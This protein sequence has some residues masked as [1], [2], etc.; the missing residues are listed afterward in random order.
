[1]R[2]ARVSEKRQT[3]RLIALCLLFAGTHALAADPT[4]WEQAEAILH[5]IQAP[6]FP[7]RDFDVRAYG[8]VADART[9]S[10]EA[11][12]KAIDDASR[13]GGGRVV[14]PPGAFTTGAIHLKSNV[15]LHVSAGATIRFSQDPAAYLPVVLTRFE[16]V[17][18]W[19]YSPLIYAYDQQNI[20]VTGGGVLEGGADANHWW[21]WKGSASGGPNQKPDRDALF[22]AADRGVPV[23]QRTFGAGHYLRPAFIETYRC[24]NVLIEGVTLKDAPMW[25][26]HPVLS[27]NVTIRGVKTIA[28]GPNT[29]GC[30]PESCRD[31]LI[32]DCY[33][34]NGDD[35]IALKSGRN[36][37]G[38]RV[39][40]PIENVVIRRCQMKNGHGGI[41]IGSEISGGARNIFAEDCTMSSPELERGLRIKTNSVRGGVIENLFFRNINVGEVGEA[42]IRIDMFYEEGDT[43]RYQPIVRNIDV[44]NMRSAKSR[45]ALYLTGYEHSPIRD[46][47]LTDCAFDGVAEGNIVRGASA[48][49]FVNVTVNGQ[50]VDATAPATA[51]TRPWS[52]RMVESAIA[53]NPDPLTVDTTDRARWNYTQGLQF[54]AIL[55]AW[56]RTGDTKYLDYVR[57][58]YD[59]MVSPDGT[60]QGYRLES[61]NIDHINAGRPLFALYRATKDEK[62]RKALDLLRSQLNQHPRNS[63]GGFWHKQIYPHQMWLDGLYM[64]SP[65]L[66][67]YGQTF[68][69]AAAGDDAALQCVLM[70]EHTRDPKTGLLY[71]AWD[72]SRQQ[73]WC[74]PATGLSKQFWGRAMGWYAMALVDVLDSLPEGHLRR[75]EVIAEV[76]RV[77]EAIVKVKDPF[78]DVWYQVLDQ[79]TRQGNYQE[80]SASAMFVYALLKGVR[81]GYLDKQYLPI[82]RKA[83][84]GILNRFVEVDAQGQVQI[85]KACSVAGLGGNPYRDGSYE[86]YVSTPVGDND[87]KAVG[88]FILASLELEALAR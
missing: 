68:G 35:C 50:R 7:D 57:R 76:K 29:D 8:A 10:T 12:R 47:R 48:L 58:Y 25:F 80:S 65:F 64:G 16:G 36:E 20:A 83:Y 1:M 66:A 69:A 75:A 13:Q 41:T 42:A 85:H 67:E 17:E 59:A 28:T 44:R 70:E 46:L 38:R 6:R 62:Y 61:F 15:N 34:D 79:P 53:R 56:R 30:N 81:K 73:R 27:T 23:A 18:C 3:S 45:Y 74:D 2:G 71:H 49:S 54:H 87:P 5:R 52:V 40:V 11:F 37:D 84:E 14:V 9:D 19:N 78:D 63:D 21:P 24:Q 55:E 33:F 72:E 4:G 86:Y 31:V 43:G 26:L 60:I 77:A 22:A 82:A 51:V 32:E 39:A 88:P